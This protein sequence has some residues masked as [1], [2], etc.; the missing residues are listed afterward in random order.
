[1]A[2]LGLSEA[3]WAQTPNGY[4]LLG[5]GVNYGN[6]LEAPREGEWGFRFD[7]KFP[8]LIKAAGFDSVR[9]PVR[10]SS[11]T[12]TKA[13]FQI[14]PEYLARVR[15][16]VE[17]NLEQGLK[18]VLNVHHFEEIFESPDAQRERLLAIWRQLSVAFQGADDRL[19]FE[20]LNEP[21]GNLTAEQWNPLL[22]EVLAEIRKLH[23]DRW[24]VIGPDDWNSIAGLSKLEL[25]QNDRRLI[26]TVHYYLPFDFTHQGA[27]WVSPRRPTGLKWTGT[28]EERAAIDQVLESHTSASTLFHGVRTRQAG[29]RTFMS[30]HVLVPGAWSVQ[31][32]HDL[33]E[34]IEA[35]LRRAVPDLTVDTHVEPLE[36][37]RSFADEGLDRRAV[38]PSARPGH[39]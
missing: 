27:S 39:T 26:V 31:R 15:H 34:T 5:R 33:V 16:V 14:D 21:H 24:V 11:A 13:P 30:V 38:P 29:Y 23:P 18:V 6:M 9:V 8:Q 20:I 35:D 25:P 19:F 37:P 2:W 28:K 3:T 10:W 17:L 1:M 7:D 32:S 12:S 22:V 36:D 4:E